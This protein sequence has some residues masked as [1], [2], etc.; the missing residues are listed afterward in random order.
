MEDR[1]KGAS[2]RK[3][4]GIVLITG[5]SRREKYLKMSSGVK[6]SATGA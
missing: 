6:W 3:I 5:F 1:R 2:M 4:A